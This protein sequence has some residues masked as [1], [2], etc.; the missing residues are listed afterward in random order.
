MLDRGTRPKLAL[1]ESL[2]KRHRTR[3]I[4]A[5]RPLTPP[6]WRAIAM[7]GGNSCRRSGEKGVPDVRDAAGTAARAARV[8]LAV[9][10]C[11]SPCAH[12]ETS[13]YL[14]RGWFGVF[15]TGIDAMADELRNR[16]IKA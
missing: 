1:R 14:L 10:V 16:G 7:Q 8:V 9:A 2:R 15:S 11:C 4:S 5:S 3:S 13:V 6:R 12:A